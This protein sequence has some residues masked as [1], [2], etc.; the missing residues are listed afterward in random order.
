MGAYAYPGL[1]GLVQAPNAQQQQ[2]THSASPREFFGNSSTGSSVYGMTMSTPPQSVSQSGYGLSAT[3]YAS[4]SPNNFNASH[5]GSN[6]NLVPGLA[7]GAYPGLPVNTAARPSLPQSDPTDTG[8]KQLIVN[9]LAPQVT[10]REMRELFEQYGPVECSRVIYEKETGVSKG[11]G[12]VYFFRSADASTAMKGMQGFEL[13]GKSL[14]V[15]FAVP[16]RPLHALAP[17]LQ[18]QQTRR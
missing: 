17:H 14:R 10:E 11:Y 15:G 16:Q 12:F 5:S 6:S 9:Y 1:S 8:P 18:G 2:F 3:V 13:Y 7:P 4:G